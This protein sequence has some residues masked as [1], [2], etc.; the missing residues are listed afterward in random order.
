MILLNIFYVK[1]YK[2]SA[3]IANDTLIHKKTRGN[4]TA[5]NIRQTSLLQSQLYRHRQGKY[6]LNSMRKNGLKDTYDIE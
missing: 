1:I 3:M 4:C 5:F 2:K 6:K